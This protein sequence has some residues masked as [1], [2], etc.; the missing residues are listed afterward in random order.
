VKRNLAFI[1]FCLL[2][3]L[4]TSS[5]YAQSPKTGFYVVITEKTGCVNTVYGLTGNTAY[6]VP[7]DPLIPA[8]EFDS[9]SE[10]EYD[11]EKNLDVV[12]LRLKPDGFRTL[13]SLAINLPYATLA[14]V[15]DGRVAG[16][17][18]SLGKVVTSNIPISGPKGSTEVDWIYAKLKKK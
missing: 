11:S 4:R 8:S 3:L 15:I 18:E 16:T 10:V 13:K 6:C 5:T 9:V 14:L 12:N 7:K 1:S 2:V 17:Y